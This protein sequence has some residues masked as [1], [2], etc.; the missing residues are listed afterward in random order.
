VTRD[1]ARRGNLRDHGEPQRGVYFGRDPKQPTGDG[2]LVRIAREARA[3]R[4]RDTSGNTVE[5][6]G[7]TTKFWLAAPGEPSAATGPAGEAA[8]SRSVSAAPTRPPQSTPVSAEWAGTARHGLTAA[9]A[10]ADERFAARRAELALSYRLTA[11]AIAAAGAPPVPIRQTWA[12][13]GRPATFLYYER[14]VRPGRPILATTTDGYRIHDTRTGQLIDHYA[15]PVRMWIA[16]APVPVSPAPMPVIVVGCGSAKAPG[17]LPAG[18]K[19]VGSFHRAARRAAAVMAARTGG[20]VLIMS[21][22]YGLVTLDTEVD[23][24]DLRIGDP[25]A[26]TAT[27]IAEQ[28]A[29]LGITDAAVTV[30][31]GRRYADLISTVWPHAARPLDGARGIGE[32]L[33]RMKAISQQGA[34]GTARELHGGDGPA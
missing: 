24:Y 30:L 17:R 18:H 21:A 6:F 31:A 22:R 16:A 11:E 9:V 2:V 3:I 28:A 33:A 20:Q 34:D 8:T 14:D 15:S 32:Q 13:A 19:Y 12:A 4:L 23:D 5:T 27:R 26:V 29:A 10:A 7:D 1:D 25:A